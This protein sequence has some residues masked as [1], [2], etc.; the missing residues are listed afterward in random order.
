M[1]SVKLGLIGALVITSTL[2]GGQP[3]DVVTS[4]SQLNTAMGTQALEN[5]LPSVSGSYGNTGAGTNALESNTTGAYNT[6]VGSWALVSNTTGSYNTACG[7]SALL[8]NIGDHNSAFGAFAMYGHSSPY[9]YN[10]A[11]GSYNTA[12]GVNAAYSN[13]SGSFNVASGYEALYSNSTADYNT[14]VGA[15][16]LQSS[17]TGESNSAYGF[18]SLQNNTTGLSNTA[19]GLE[20]LNTNITGNGNVAIGVEAGYYTTGSNNIDIGNMGTVGESNTIRIGAPGAQSAVYLSGVSTSQITGS[21]V[22]VTASG[23]LGVLASSERY[24]TDVRAMTST[25][26]LYSL[27]PV[28]FHLKADPDGDIQYG[29]IAEE[30]AKVYPELAIRDSAG[31]I[32]GV[33]YDELAPM[34]LNEM[35]HQQAAAAAQAETISTQGAAIN[36]LKRQLA[37]MQASVAELQGRSERM[38]QR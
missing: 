20:S 10:Q 21:A 27:R 16:A 6:A 36:Q 18:A 30:V 31:R 8:Q 3:P 19:V 17:N 28:T 37:M 33:R 15:Y 7:S 35:Q 11:T 14:A 1:K 26:R 34:L 24:K 29:L 2:Y 22:Y 9:L 5:L 12:S 25:E 4:D 38:A 13:A 32:E 23:E